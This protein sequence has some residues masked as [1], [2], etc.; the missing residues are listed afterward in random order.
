M[1]G[2]VLAYAGLWLL[3]RPGG[4]P[5]GR[6]LAQLAGTEGVL[7]LS[8]SLVL[9]ASTRFEHPLRD[10]DRLAAWHRLTAVGGTLLI[11]PHV[12]LVGSPPNP[13]ATGLGKPLGVVG[14]IGI[15]GL[16]AW[17]LVV[18][19]RAGFLVRLRG[20]AD[21]AWTRRPRASSA[22]DR[23]RLIHRTTGL[24]VTAAFAHGALDGTPFA[25]STALYASYLLAGAVGILAYLYCELLGR[26][27]RGV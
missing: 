16:V 20:A 19:G 4:E 9:V 15:V 26:R 21:R 6:Y 18:H 10:V 5:W 1:G 14:A 3:A 2:L 27:A 23:W 25:S 11:L 7:L 8:A 17:A 22:Y 13:S 12:A 24:F